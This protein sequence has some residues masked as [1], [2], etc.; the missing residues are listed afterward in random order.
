[1]LADDE[2]YFVAAAD[3]VER[4]LVV[5]GHEEKEARRIVIVGGGNIGLFL[6]KEIESNYPD[7]RVRLIE[8]DLARA[9]EI[10]DELGHT[11]VLHG[12]ALDQDILRE[13]NIR[14][15]ETIVA[16]TNDDKVNI[17]ASLLAKGGGVPTSDGARQ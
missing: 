7:V 5:F 13:A 4:A 1:M 6:A 8:S 14:E 9:E 16:V 17:L 10:V 11:V 15:T 12:D 3:H 2:V